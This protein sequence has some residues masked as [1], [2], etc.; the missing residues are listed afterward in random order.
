M[1][2]TAAGIGTLAQLV[3]TAADAGDPLALEVLAD[4]GVELARLG[5]ALIARAGPL[6]VAVVGGVVMLHAEIRAAT[7]ALLGIPLSF[8]RIDA[9]LRAAGAGARQSQAGVTMVST[10]SASPR[11][12]HIEDWSSAELVDGIVEA[13]FAAVGA[14]QAAAAAIAAAAD[15]A[16]ERLDRGGR[17]VYVGAGTSGRIA[18]QD[19][20]ELPPTFNWP[21]ERAVPVMAGGE[22]ALTHAVHKVL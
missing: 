20:A 4:A 1:A 16:A 18:T 17:L 21:Y 8:P 7:A 22:R 15:A 3:A 14:V 6:P 9:A 12:A 2:A 19:A 10:E 11:F 5:Q 13:Q